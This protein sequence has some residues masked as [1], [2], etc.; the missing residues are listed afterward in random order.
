MSDSTVWTGSSDFSTTVNPTPFAFYD[1]DLAFA[2][3]ADKV[4]SFCAIRLGYLQ[5]DVELNPKSLY[6]CFEEAV[7][8]YGTGVYQHLIQ[9]NYLSLEGGSTTGT[10]NNTVLK[11]TLQRLIEITKNYGTEAGVGAN[12][13]KYSTLID[14]TK[15]EP[16]YDLDVAIKEGGVVIEGGIEIR[17]VF[18][19]APPAILRYFDPNAGTGTQ[20]VMDAFDFGDMSPAINFLMMPA[21]FD[22]MKVQAIE[23]NDQIRRSAYSFELN[24]NKLTLFPIPLAA[25]KV[26]VEYYK[27]DEKKNNHDGTGEA[28]IANPSNVPYGNPIYSQINSVGRQWIFSYTLALAKELLAYTR[29]K[30]GTVPVPGSDVTLNHADL[31]SDARTEKL[32]LLED[33]HAMLDMTSRKTQ[34]ERRAEESE[35]LKKTLDGVP[36]LIY[37]G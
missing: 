22:L 26:R 37:V 13:T 5:L 24:N 28:L 16:T 7:T 17:K 32:K 20:H 33:L 10:L 6:T 14:V 21:S 30:Y 25:G 36:M 27:L 11:P 34:L 4:A 31:L 29:G 19:E 1:T 3:D 18:Y 9:D 35:N 8:T 12:I 15:G 23:F 2:G